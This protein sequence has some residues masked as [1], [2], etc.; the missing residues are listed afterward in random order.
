MAWLA[1]L[2]LRDARSAAFYL[3]NGGM[4]TASFM[5]STKVTNTVW[6]LHIRHGALQDVPTHELSHPE[7]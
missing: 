5:R 6:I 7:K 4:F 3:V 1:K 2:R